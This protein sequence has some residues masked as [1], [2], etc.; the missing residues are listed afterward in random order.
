MLTHQKRGISSKQHGAEIFE[1]AGDDLQAT[2]DSHF[3]S[4]G[5]VEA[6]LQIIYSYLQ[7]K[8]PKN[9]CACQYVI[10]NSFLHR[11]PG[12]SWPITLA[13]AFSRERE[14]LAIIED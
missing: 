5:V 3:I 13:A 8:K 6:Q 11:L 9:T 14:V 4:F 1:R 10:C 12:L 7:K 2:W